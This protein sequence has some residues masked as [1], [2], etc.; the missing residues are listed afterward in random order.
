MGV[1]KAGEAPL[2]RWFESAD[3]LLVLLGGLN[4]IGCLYPLGVTGSTAV[5][6]TAGRGSSPLVGVVAV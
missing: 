2:A 4:F 6:K 1:A 3:L 5:S